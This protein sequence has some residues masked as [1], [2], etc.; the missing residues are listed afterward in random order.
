MFQDAF[1]SS[2]TFTQ[3]WYCSLFYLGKNN[4]SWIWHPTSCPATGAAVFGVW[5]ITR[6]LISRKF[7]HN[8][9]YYVTAKKRLLWQAPLSVIKS[10][11]CMIL[12]NSSA[13][14]SL[15][16]RRMTREEKN[17]QLLV[18]VPKEI[19]E[20]SDLIAQVYFSVVNVLWYNFFNF[21][22]S[23]FGVNFPSLF[24]T[25]MTLWVNYMLL[26]GV[27]VDFSSFQTYD[28]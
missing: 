27:S 7:S 11:K 28:C 5:L 9:G 13:N 22:T 23:Y 19:L 3:H 18:V 1:S 2:I 24:I 4:I 16:V 12:L 14:G 21:Q 15:L 26:H 20:S 10:K 25:V 6:K 17:L 8:C